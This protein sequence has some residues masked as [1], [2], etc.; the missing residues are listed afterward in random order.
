MGYNKVRN[1]Q[2]WSMSRQALVMGM[3]SSNELGEPTASYK[4]LVI[5]TNNRVKLKTSRK[6]PITLEESIEDTLN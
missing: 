4:L 3:V 5:L 6:L 1:K 2:P